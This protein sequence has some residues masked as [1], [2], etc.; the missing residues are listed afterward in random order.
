MILIFF[1]VLAIFIM[2]TLIV[3]FAIS[4]SRKCNKQYEDFAVKNNYRFDKAM[5]RTLSQKKAKKTFNLGIEIFRNPLIDK[6]ADFKSYPFNAGTDKIVSF[7][8]EGTY[9]QQKFRAFNYQFFGSI[10]DGKGNGGNFSILM[11]KCKDNFNNIKAGSNM[12]FEKNW[13]CYFEDGNLEVKTIHN[14]IDKLKQVLEG[15]KKN[16]C[17]K[18]SK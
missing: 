9:K 10:L 5:G 17:K 7:V 13:L 18:I 16:G 2:T 11:I 8:I 12:F 6:Y 14:N 3:Y 1:I 15:E 4:K